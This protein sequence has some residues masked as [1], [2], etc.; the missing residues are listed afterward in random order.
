MLQTD[1]PKYQ[2]LKDYIIETIKS[3]QLNTGDKFFSENELSER[4]DISRHTIRQA[5]GELV[6]EGWLYRV[7]GKGTF[8]NRRPDQKHRGSKIIGVLSGCLDSCSSLP[9]I[10]GIYDILSQNGYNMFL[11]Y[12]YNSH[13]KERLCLENLL[14]QDISGLIVE[15]VKSALP[16]PNIDIYKKF[17]KLNIPTLFIHGCYRELDYSYIGEDD[18]EAG[19]A[20]ARHL[21][22]LGHEKISGIFKMDDIQGLLRF[23]GFQKAHIEAGLQVPDSNILWFETEDMDTKLG[24]NAGY[25]ENLISQ[26]TAVV[27]YD[28]E[29]VLRVLDTLRYKGLK[30]PDDI[31]IVSLDTSKILSASPIK[32]TKVLYPRESLGEKCGEAII[33]MIERTQDYYDEI[34]KPEL[35]IMESTKKLMGGN[36]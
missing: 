15:P 5:V 10:K 31:S 11:G 28:D 23:S 35:I 1:K 12:T 19:Y 18:T 13:E 32:F 34:I 4:F 3:E 2:M 20:A 7:Q 22:S 8:V 24:L 6:N 17:G 16:N 21:L 26:C 14:S 30:I 9:I 29:V 36:E 27:C 25:L 33:S